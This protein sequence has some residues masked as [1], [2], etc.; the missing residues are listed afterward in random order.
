MSEPIWTEEQ[1]AKLNA[2]Q[3]DGRVHPYT[4]P[5]SRSFCEGQRSLIATR[6]GWVCRCGQY[7]QGWAHGVE[8]PLPAEDA[9]RGARLVVRLAE[10]LQEVARLEAT[11]R[12]LREEITRLRRAMFAGTS[13]LAAALS[14]STEE[15]LAAAGVPLSQEADDAG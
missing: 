13:Q 14:S 2:H 15:A 11:E 1:V 5:G 4:C 3:A 10:A 6:D 9:R 7:R 12:V 8:A